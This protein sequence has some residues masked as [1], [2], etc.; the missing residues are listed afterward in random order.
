[1][2]TEKSWIANN[3][4]H[5]IALFVMVVWGLLSIKITQELLRGNKA[6]V[7]TLM[8]FWAGISGT[9]INVL[10]YYFG[11]SSGSRSKDETIKD[12]SK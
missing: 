2:D 12:L 10:S 8:A 3:I 11:S 7:T 4:S 5:I 9:F 1:M 6:D